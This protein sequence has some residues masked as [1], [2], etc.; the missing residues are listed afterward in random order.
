MKLVRVCALC[1]PLCGIYIEISF[2]CVCDRLLVF[3]PWLEVSRASCELNDIFRR[4]M[5]NQVKQCV[6]YFPFK[7]H[8]KRAAKCGTSKPVSVVRNPFVYEITKEKYNPH[9]THVLMVCTLPFEGM[10]H[11]LVL[12]S[13]NVFLQKLV[14]NTKFAINAVLMLISINVVLPLK[15]S[16]CCSSKEWNK[17][18]NILL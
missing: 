3:F 17:L 18:I 1:A 10:L 11:T 12:R 15:T 4:R 2:F 14:T 8:R 16:S 7:V 5:N 6:I 9:S 13:I